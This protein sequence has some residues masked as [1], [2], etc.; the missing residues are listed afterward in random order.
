MSTQKIGEWK[1]ERKGNNKLVVTLPDGMEVGGNDI[2]VEDL[3]SAIA[4]QKAIK[5]GRTVVKCCSGN[6]AIA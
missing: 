2:T 1:I 6:V 3:L 5:T 4:T